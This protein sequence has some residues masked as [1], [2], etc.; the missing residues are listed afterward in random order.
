MLGIPTAPHGTASRHATGEHAE[1]MPDKYSVMY[2]SV[3]QCGTDTMGC[4]RGGHSSHLLPVKLLCRLGSHFRRDRR[5]ITAKP[6]RAHWVGTA[7]DTSP[8]SPPDMR[9][10]PTKHTRAHTHTYIH[11]RAHTHTY[12][13]T[14]THIYMHTHTHTRLHNQVVAP[15]TNSSSS[16][17]AATDSGDGD[18]TGV[19]LC[20]VCT[21]TCVG[22]SGR[23]QWRVCVL[24][25]VCLRGASV[26]LCNGGLWRRNG[27]QS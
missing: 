26:C 20:A 6:L 1:G 15:L 8:L 22:Q 14:H 19:G 9:R 27:G 18:T 11:T 12:T 21:N 17:G 13:H 5:V 3:T 7:R 2:Q 10:R 23:R 16:A 24:A 4:L 25:C